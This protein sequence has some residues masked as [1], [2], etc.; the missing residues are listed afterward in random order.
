M[1]F[2]LIALAA[3]IVP[4][5]VRLVAGDRAGAV[6][7]AVSDAVR[8]ATGTED[9]VEAKR[10]IDE[11]P[12]IAAQLRTRLAEIAVEQERMRLD[13][14]EKQRAAELAE[15]EK[16]L[17]DVQNARATMLQL[18]AGKDPMRWGPPVVSVVVT[19]TFVLALLV[20]TLPS[21]FTIADGTKELVNIVLGALVAAFTAVINFWIGSSQGSRDKDATVR[22]LQ[23]AQAEHANRALANQAQQ[24]SAALSSQ[25]E[26]TQAAI[27]GLKQVASTSAASSPPSPIVPIALAAGAAAAGAA[28]TAAKRGAFGAAIELVLDEEGGFSDHPRDKGGPTNFGITYRTYAAF[29][30]MD[31]EKVTEQMMRELT[32]EQAIEIYRANYW[33][34]ARCDALPP[35][36]DLCV[37]DFA[38]NAGVR[39]AI[40]TLQ[41]V[42][43][44]T[45]DG[46]IGPI[47]L[48]AVA[49]CDKERAIRQ[50]AEK[51][52]AYYR[53][54]ADFDA[55]GRGWTV[56][57]IAIR[58][59]GL[60]MAAQARQPETAVA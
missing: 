37:F 42:V 13:A 6:T 44:V 19:L 15:L 57:S 21:V 50:F 34:P 38:V 7:S 14:E 53:S 47:T 3:T 52:L 41:E 9:P 5:I 8:V 40:R 58:D 60:R 23:A 18:S 31:P 36:L 12:Q 54:L 10:K 22:A 59:A 35:G 30:E 28:A 56:R 27:A 25:T 4:E 16:R 49:A 48:A 45:A 32:R 1:P 46:S 39:T 17:A 51:R 29:H 33:T 55:F 11:D 43:G 26:T 2:P 20:F 24:A